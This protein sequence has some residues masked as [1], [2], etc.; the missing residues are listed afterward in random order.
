MKNRK[1]YYVIPIFVFALTF[2]LLKTFDNKSY[3]AVNTPT[4]VNIEEGTKFKFSYKNTYSHYH[5]TN[6]FR[7]SASGTKVLKNSENN[8]VVVYCAEQGKTL[9]SKYNRTRYSL[10]SSNVSIK[11]S[12]KDKLNIMM[13]YAYPYITLSELKNYLKSEQ[14]GLDQATYDKYEFD[15]LNVQ[16]TI[17]AVQASIWN[18][19]KGTTTEFR[20]N[21]KITGSNDSSLKKFNTCES[22]YKDKILT[23][24]E[25]NWYNESGCNTNGNFYKYVYSLN[26]SGAK[27][28]VNTLI[29]WYVSTLISKANTAT[30]ADNYKI[31]NKN[32]TVNGDTLTLTVEI[33][34]NVN[35]YSVIFKDINGTTILETN[36]SNGNVYTINNLPKDT[37]EISAEVRSNEKKK[38]IYYYK[39]SGQDFIGVENT[40]YTNTLQISNDGT[41]QII[42]Y[43]VRNYDK[44]VSVRYDLNQVDTSICGTKDN[45]CLSDADFVLYAENKKYVKSSISTTNLTGTEDLVNTPIIISGLPV[46]TYYLIEE[47]PPVGYE[48]YKYNTDTVDS[49]GYIKIEISEGGIASV[50]V[51]NDPTKICISKV[52]KDNN[53]KI[54]DGAEF[55][56]EDIDESLYVEFNTSNQ[57]G[58]Y[59]LE[60]VLPI[61]TYYLLETKAPTG[62]IKTFDK[63]RFTVGKNIETTIVD[64]VNVIDINKTNNNLI[65][66]NTKGVSKTDITTGACVAGAKLSI[67]DKTGKEVDSWISECES[68]KEI[69][70]LNLDPGTYTL[71]EELAPVGYAT[72]ESITFTIK[73]DGTVDKS[74]N[75][76]DAPIN[77]CIL[78]T[79]KNISD[80]LE[81]AEFEIYDE[82]GNLYTTFTSQKSCTSFPYM[83]VGNYTI[84]EVKAP[85]GYKITNKETLITVKDTK[86]TQN[87]EIENEVDVPKTA[88]DFSK[89]IL[90][91][92]SIFMIFGIGLVAYYGY[93]KQ[94]KD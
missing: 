76:E 59:C 17:T 61:G 4:T 15:K 70:S 7:Q 55:F 30:I 90:V 19:M 33:E 6:N 29:D 85:K 91:I 52:D 46:G 25:E 20:Y 74:L 79:A 11:T 63:F 49:E 58:A 66:K 60:G 89:T 12:I 28:R 83:P 72:A 38:N 42:I 82:Q 57:E 13:N 67:K 39:G 40:Q 48:F 26:S 36:N 45:Q 44:N 65:I 75:M 56:I 81:G 27:E 93:K 50:I 84:K 14:I 43:K 68:G 53:S 87:F 22:Y 77:V 78:K 1:L 47:Q 23:T 37:K 80:G 35:N 18:I 32:F 71:T 73:E 16:E 24:E 41:G 54:L 9:G 86:Q 64:D 10:A 69:H 62:Y 5:I 51:N 2:V 94:V 8:K 3:A 88:M 21:K 31:K 34:T 92:A